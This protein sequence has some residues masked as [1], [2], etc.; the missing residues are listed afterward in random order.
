MSTQARIKRLASET[1]VYGVSSIVGRLINFLLFP[2]YSQVFAP[3]VYEPIIV[4]YLS[5]IHI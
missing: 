4:L 3:D 2:L 1:A 5:L